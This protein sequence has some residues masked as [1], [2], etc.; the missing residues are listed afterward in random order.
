VL[1]VDNVVHAIALDGVSV[2]QES[3]DAVQIILRYTVF[4]Q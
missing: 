2:V 1:V 3:R 4:S